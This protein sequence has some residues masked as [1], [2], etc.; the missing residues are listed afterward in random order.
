MASEVRQQVIDSDK[1]LVEQTMNEVVRKIITVNFGAA[2]S[3]P[4]SMPTPMPRFTLFEEQDLSRQRAERDKIL[5]DMKVFGFTKAY[6][7][8]HYDFEDSDIE[9]MPLASATS[10]AAFE[11]S[12]DLAGLSTDDAPDQEA[13]STA[14]D[15]LVGSNDATVQSMIAPALALIRAGSDYG[16]VAVALE[17]IYGKIDTATLERVLE[18]A[19]FAADAT[20]RLSER[21]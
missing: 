17:K 1:R 3:T 19:M 20:G 18:Q 10:T 9:M 21:Q 7:M 15:A 5:A 14:G 8:A 12:S 4:M 13:V 16:D 6:F 2:D 11:E